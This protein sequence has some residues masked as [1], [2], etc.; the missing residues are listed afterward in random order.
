[1]KGAKQP[2]QILQDY[3]GLVK[4][5]NSAFSMRALARDLSLSPTFVAQMLSGKKAFPIQRFAQIAD[6]LG[7]DEI[8][9]KTLRQSLRKHS[10]KH[11]SEASLVEEKIEANSEAIS[12]MADFEMLSKHDYKVL[13]KW[14]ILPILD[15]TTCRNFVSA[16]KDIASRLG[17]RLEE[18][19]SAVSLLL[20]LELLKNED[21]VLKKTNRNMRFPAVA[22]HPAIRS[23]H[24][25]MMKMALLQ[26]KTKTEQNHYDNRLISG[27]MCAVN[28]ANIAKAKEHLHKA[29]YEAALILSEGECTEVYQINTQFFPLTATASI[30]QE[31]ETE[32]NI[33]LPSGG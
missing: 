16:E 31:K 3:F 2:F 32:E 20:E 17:L 23:F 8:G 30:K 13:E 6:A 21:G 29:M 4:E 10:L 28:P 14:Y 33:Q 18:A 15:L 1:M 12:M 27:V 19:K 22:S 5:R 25:Q 24:E 7:I 11:Y 9:R 26:L